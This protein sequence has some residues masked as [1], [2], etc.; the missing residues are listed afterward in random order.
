MDDLTTM[1]LIAWLALSRDAEHRTDGVVGE[2]MSAM[3]PLSTRIIADSPARDVARTRA[4]ALPAT[5]TRP[6]L[7][8][9]AGDSR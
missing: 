4:F 2:P 1:S 8:S 3:A 5:V 7:R 9:P 6:K